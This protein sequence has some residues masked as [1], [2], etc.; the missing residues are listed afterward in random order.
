[1]I[2]PVEAHYCILLLLQH[3]GLVFVKLCTLEFENFK[4]FSFSD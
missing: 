3:F 2:N 1:M 4:I